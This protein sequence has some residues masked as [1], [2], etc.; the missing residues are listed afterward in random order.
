MGGKWRGE[1][2]ERR[3]EKREKKEKRRKGEGGEGG[4][5]EDR[6]GIRMTEIVELIIEEYENM[7]NERTKIVSVIHVSNALGTI[8]P[9]EE[10]R[11][12][13]NPSQIKKRNRMIPSPCGVSV[14]IGAGWSGRMVCT[15]C[16]FSRP[17]SQVGG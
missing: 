12:T 10:R 5:V 16:P 7:L 15:Q 8:N 11:A 13:A 3:G 17:D 9:G 1:G 2:E 6:G 4:E 14:A